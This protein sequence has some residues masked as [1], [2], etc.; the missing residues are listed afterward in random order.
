MLINLL[1]IIIFYLSF[2]HICPI[3]FVIK[4]LISLSIVSCLSYHCFGNIVKENEIAFSR[5]KVLLVSYKLIFVLNVLFH[6]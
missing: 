3:I 5:F 1:F 6:L 2:R 4:N